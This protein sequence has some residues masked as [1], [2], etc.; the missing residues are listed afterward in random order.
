MTR[1]PLE[2]LVDMAVESSGDLCDGDC[3]GWHSCRF[4]SGVLRIEYQAHEISEFT[5]THADFVE[6]GL[7][8]EAL[9]ATGMGGG[10]KEWWADLLKKRL[11]TPVLREYGPS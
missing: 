7:L 10:T 11:N 2:T 4:G 1:L 5:D 6:V 8:L 9:A 3:P